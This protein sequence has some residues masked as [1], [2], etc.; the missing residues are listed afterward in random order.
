MKAHTTMDMKT[1]LTELLHGHLRE[2]FVIDYLQK[3]YA[4]V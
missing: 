3:N 2:E 1:F 4:R